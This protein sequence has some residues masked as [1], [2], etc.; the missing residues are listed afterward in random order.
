MLEDTAIKK[1]KGITIKLSYGDFYKK[2]STGEL[3]APRNFAPYIGIDPRKYSQLFEKEKNKK[4]FK[5]CFDVLLEI[6]KRI[7]PE[8]AK[9]LIPLAMF[10]MQYASDTFPAF[11]LIYPE[12]IADDWLAMTGWHRYQRDH[13]IHQPLTAYTVMQLLSDENIIN[14]KNQTLLGLCA[15]VIHSGPGSDYLRKFLHRMGV[16][17]SF[18]SDY[19]SN[20]K[21]DRDRNFGLELCKL[22]FFEAAFVA[23]MFHDLGY[24]WQYRQRLGKMFLPADSS[25]ALKYNSHIID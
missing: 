16:S 22:L 19:F 20:K 2:W 3:K 9:K 6:E 4:E 23:A 12:I 21:T 8:Y 18:H 24:P 1:E 17:R 13:L 25:T 15:E 5:S 10:S 14:D 7:N 11:S